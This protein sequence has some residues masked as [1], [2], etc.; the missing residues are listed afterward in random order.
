MT[1]KNIKIISFWSTFNYQSNFILNLLK[2]YNI[3]YR[4]N[5]NEPDI[6]FVG[7][8]VK[9]DGI[10]CIKNFNGIKIL[11]IT[12]PISKTQKHTYEL[13]K[14]NIFDL[15]FGC[16]KNDIEINHFK[17]P[18]YI[19]YSYNCYSNK[20]YFEINE[21]ILNENIEQKKF[22]TL[23]NRHD[24][25]GTRSNIYNSLKNIGDIDCPSKLYNN[26]SNQE[27]NSIGNIKF[28]NKYTFNLCPENSKCE[29]DG[30]ITEKLMNCCLSGAIPIYFGSFDE[31]DEKI[32]NKNRII[33]F[34]PYEQESINRA[35]KYIE[36]L[37][38]DKEKLNHFYKQHI[39]NDEAYDT[40]NNM[41]INL[42]N[43]IKLF[44]N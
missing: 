36:E 15:V 19:L 11:I 10:D 28:I 41:E 31:I 3:K 38:N 5:S 27:L 17:Y 16:V 39:F 26:T 42:I 9:Y 12:E 35:S 32:F 1:E 40:I 20:K 22:C 4:Y 29:F 13:F 37:M 30:Y 2:K 25:Y 33:F 7:S 14:T 6:L 18:L 43:N 23:I 21:K 34:N 8:F 44:F 24:M